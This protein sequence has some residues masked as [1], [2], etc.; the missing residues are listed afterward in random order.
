MSLIC[1]ILIKKLIFIIFSLFII[2]LK[3]TIG[4]IILFIYI[5]EYFY[6]T[7]FLTDI[8]KNFNDYYLLEAEDIDISS[9]NILKLWNE[10]CKLQAFKRLYILFSK[11]I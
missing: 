7:S 5:P 4:L 11:K 1:N 6:L 3:P 8:Y 2:Y 9:L 10:I